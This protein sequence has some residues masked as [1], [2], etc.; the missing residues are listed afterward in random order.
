MSLFLYFFLRGIISAF[1]R[2]REAFFT[3][4]ASGTAYDIRRSKISVL[5][6]VNALIA[7]SVRLVPI[8]YYLF[9]RTQFFASRVII[10]ISSKAKKTEQLT[11]TTHESD[12]KKQG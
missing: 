1:L 12:R 6:A 10:L 11:L 2:A 8:K 5:T 3:R 4:T 9:E 7:R